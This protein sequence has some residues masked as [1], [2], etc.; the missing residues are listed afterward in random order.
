MFKLIALLLVNVTLIAQ[1]NLQKEYEVIDSEIKISTIIANAKDDTLIY[2]I[3]PGR[4]TKKVKTKELV[5]TLKKYGYTDIDTKD[6]Y[7]KFIQ[8]SPID[9]SKIKEEIHKNYLEKYKSIEIQSI[10][11]KPRSYTKSLPSNYTVKLQNKGHL[12]KEGVVSI[13]SDTSRQ[14]F[15]D[16]FIDATLDVYVARK[17][18]KRNSE[19]STINTT[20]K[21]IILEKFRAMPIENIELAHL[22][23][24]RYI[25]KDTVITHRDTREL[26]LIKRGS[27]I[28][29]TLNNSNIAISF[30]AKA[31]ENGVLGD[32]IKVKQKN[33]KILKV[34][35]VGRNRGEA[36]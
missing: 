29:V 4:Y 10:K 26:Q 7:V 18:I 36:L 32:I 30:S 2:K 19:L 33:Q 35:I 21:S 1:I 23:S 25:K 24:K 22:Q 5:E 8:K 28:N 14:V 3:T 12:N 13:K 15:F 20:K 16:Y 11:V 17:D 27:I 31:L 9:T 6:K 34:K